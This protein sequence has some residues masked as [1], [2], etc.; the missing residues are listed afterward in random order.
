MFKISIFLASN[1]L[2]SK[3]YVDSVATGLH[4]K[5]AVCAATTVPITLSGNQT[6]DGFAT[7]TGNRI[8]VKN[9]ADTTTNGIYSANTGSWGRTSDYNGTT[10][11]G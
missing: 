6:I 4:V 9:Q 3:I 10:G 7:S 1:S 8:L 5:A 11:D 2:V